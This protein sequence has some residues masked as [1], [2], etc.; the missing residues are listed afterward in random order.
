MKYLNFA[1]LQQKLGNRSRS[2]LY[3]DIDANRIPQPIRLGG[4]LY[5]KEEDI[6]AAM[7]RHLN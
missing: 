3:R 5:W 7:K 2:S 6:D 4:R 1:E